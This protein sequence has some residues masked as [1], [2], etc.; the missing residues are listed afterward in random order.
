VRAAQAIV[1]AVTSENPPLHLLLGSFAYEQAT[2]KLDNLRKE[3][4]TWREVTV[5]ADFKSDTH[6]VNS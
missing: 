1:K 3:F 4:E 6:L 2:A 5:G